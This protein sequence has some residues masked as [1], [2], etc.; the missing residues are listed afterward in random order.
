MAGSDDGGAKV[1]KPSRSEELVSAEEQERRAAAV[2]QKLEALLP[3]R[4]LKP[5]R[6]E[7]DE[8]LSTALESEAQP[9]SDPPELLRF[10]ELEA[11]SE[12]L[13]LDG[14]AVIV[15]EDE[16]VDTKYYDDFVLKG[17]VHYTTGA[18]FIKL[19]P[20]ET[21]PFHLSDDDQA[22]PGELIHHGGNPATN[23]W[24]PAPQA[25]FPVDSSKPARSESL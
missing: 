9:F 24:V 7:V 13:P 8:L 12:K 2:R 18:G 15:V 1:E 16:Y 3:K 17:V 21:P 20:P 10:Q 4:P 23:E 6:S 5:S 25:S 22:L 11:S 19:D 14:P